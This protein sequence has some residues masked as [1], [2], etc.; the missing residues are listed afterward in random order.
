[1]DDRDQSPLPDAITVLDEQVDRVRLVEPAI[2]DPERYQIDREIGR[3]GMGVVQLIRD[4]RIGR[5]IARKLMR[6]DHAGDPEARA[7]F[8]REVQVQGQLEHPA[9]VPVYDL[10]EGGGG[11]PSFTMKTI[12]GRTLHEIIA[13]LR[14]GEPD[15]ARQYTRHKLLSAFGGVCLA[16]DYA[17][18]RGVLHR[19]LK[20]SNLMLGDFGEVYVLD[21]GIAK[22][23]SNAQTESGMIATS[24]AE[25]RD[26][27][28]L[29]RRNARV[30]RPRRAARQAGECR[31]RRVC[32]GRGAVRAADVRAADRARV[33]GRADR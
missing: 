7:R 4:R 25:A 2:P 6:A 9:I 19:D 23:T 14:T 24:G 21:W 13:A 10:D 27:A 32:A 20:P 26:G 30:P 18:Q 11:A 22:I 15:A 1:M 31:Q 3:G 29:V 8:L 17:H 28:R 5:S 33:D 16:I 12:R